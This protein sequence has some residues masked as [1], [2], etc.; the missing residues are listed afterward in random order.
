MRVFAP[1]GDFA[2]IGV[3][4]PCAIK[5]QEKNDIIGFSHPHSDDRQTIP[6][7]RSLGHECLWIGAEEPHLQCDILEATLLSVRD[8]AVHVYNEN[9]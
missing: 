3:M 4:V 2:L 9:A 6:R 5:T 1:I 8:T 7:V